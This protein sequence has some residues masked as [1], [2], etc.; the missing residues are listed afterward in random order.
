[1]GSKPFEPPGRNTAGV[2]Q[3]CACALFLLPLLGCAGGSLALCWFR[4]EV[5][6]G[7]KNALQGHR[8]ETAFVQIGLRFDFET[9]TDNP[10]PL[11]FAVSRQ[12]SAPASGVATPSAQRYGVVFI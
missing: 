9:E 10:W 1:M 12:Q 5:S 11:F 4:I 3:E 7:A 2:P 6:Y 8:G